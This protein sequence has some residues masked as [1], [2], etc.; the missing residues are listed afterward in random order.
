MTRDFSSLK[1]APSPYI[2]ERHKAQKLDS[3]FKADL[4]F[5]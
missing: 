5:A 1:V 3:E 2:I 4:Y